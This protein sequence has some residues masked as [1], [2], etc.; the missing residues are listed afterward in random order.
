MLKCIL[1]NKKYFVEASSQEGI[2]D[3]RQLLDDEFAGK[4]WEVL[5]AVGGSGSGIEENGTSEINSQGL[6]EVQM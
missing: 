5:G 1:I 6:K 2:N 4:E 3:I